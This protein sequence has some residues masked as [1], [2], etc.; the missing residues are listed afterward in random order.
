MTDLLLKNKKLLN[1]EIIGFNYDNEV[2][3]NEIG[4]LIT[5]FKYGDSKISITDK[6]VFYNYIIDNNGNNDKYR[7]IINNFIT[8]IEYLNK[9]KN[10]ENNTITGNTKIY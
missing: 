6:V 2:F 8:L 9:I 3:V 1:N 4:D 7:I 5:N 10:D